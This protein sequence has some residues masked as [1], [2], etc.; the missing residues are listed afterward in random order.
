MGLIAPPRSVNTLSPLLLASLWR[1][2]PRIDQFITSLSEPWLEIPPNGFS[3][4]KQ[5]LGALHVVPSLLGPLENCCTP[6]K[7]DPSYYP[8]YLWVSFVPAP[9]GNAPKT[10]VIV[11]LLLAAKFLETPRKVT[12]S[13][14]L[15]IRYQWTLLKII[16]KT[17]L[18][19]PF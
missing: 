4:Q 5:P 11:D 1:R 18:D 3:P 14:Y 19:K 2:L 13:N 9:S 8:H 15:I 16:N 17:L 6:Y 12:L 7:C 10:K